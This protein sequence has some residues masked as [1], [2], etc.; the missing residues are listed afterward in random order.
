MKLLGGLA[1]SC[2]YGNFILLPK[3][4]TTSVKKQV[5]FLNY[6]PEEYFHKN[7]PSKTSSII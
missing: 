5:I 2:L 3:P 1:M 4:L 7:V 6:Y